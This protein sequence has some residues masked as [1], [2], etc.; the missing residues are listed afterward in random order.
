[1]ALPLDARWVGFDG[2]DRFNGFKGSRKLIP[3][4]PLKPFQPLKPFTPPSLS[5]EESAVIQG[6]L[7]DDGPGLVHVCLST[8][9]RAQEVSIPEHSRK[10]L[11][12]FAVM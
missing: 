7:C 1:M 11:G 9:V 8:V 12:L 6:V 5:K 3:I 10:L 2:F 4:N